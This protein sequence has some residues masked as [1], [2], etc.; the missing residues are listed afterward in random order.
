MF[1]VAQ[2]HCM[3]KAPLSG[4][5]N[6]CT[7][8]LQFVTSPDYSSIPKF[9][10][11]E[12]S[13]PKYWE[14]SAETTKRLHTAAASFHEIWKN[15]DASIADKILDKDVKDYNLMFGGEPKVGSDAF[16]SMI[17]GVIKVILFYICL[18]FNTQFLRICVFTYIYVFLHIYKS[19]VLLS[20]NACCM[21]FLWLEL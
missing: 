16:K 5:L 14:P 12:F 6:W 18:S 11:P 3:H 15:G 13:D 2:H 19:F 4:K 7:V 9:V 21:T 10:G 20:K 17:N 8:P 1:V